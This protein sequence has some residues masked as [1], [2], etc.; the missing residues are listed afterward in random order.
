MSMK[1]AIL[2]QFYAN[3]MLIMPWHVICSIESQVVLSSA[4]IH[5]LTNFPLSDSPLFLGEYLRSVTKPS[6]IGNL[7]RKSKSLGQ[8]NMNIFE[9]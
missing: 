6:K 4:V 1:Y 8:G 7:Q 5:A 3:E 9:I 2:C